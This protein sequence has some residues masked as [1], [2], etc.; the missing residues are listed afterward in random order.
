MSENYDLILR[1][2]GYGLDFLQMITVP[3]LLLAL[4]GRLAR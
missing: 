3:L 4:T 2:L 1:S